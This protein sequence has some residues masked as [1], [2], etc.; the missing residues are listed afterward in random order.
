MV[1]L[2]I[3][4]KVYTGCVINSVLRSNSAV[5]LD[6]RVANSSTALGISPSKPL[7]GYQEGSSGLSEVYPGGL[8]RRVLMEGYQ[9]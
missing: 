3:F 8:S 7:T 1:C 4:L 5:G 6:E 2:G 9:G